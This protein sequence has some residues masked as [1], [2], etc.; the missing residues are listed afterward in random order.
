MHTGSCLCGAVK[1]EIRGEFGAGFFCHCTRCRKASGSAFASNIL[2]ATQD[3]VI[4][5][6]AEAV[7]V[8]S[9]KLGVH[10]HFCGECGSPLI[11]KRDAMPEVVR[12]RVGT[13]DTPLAHGPQAHIYVGSKA[14]WYEIHDELPQY[15]DRPPA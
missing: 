7:K 3:F 14:D 10:R 6:G 2:A 4:T 1:Y 5:Q 15:P 9:T 13:L 11:S 12:V 8:F